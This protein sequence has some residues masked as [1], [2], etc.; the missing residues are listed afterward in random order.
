MNLPL[1]QQRRRRRAQRLRFK[2]KDV[3]ARVVANDTGG[4]ALPPK[5]AAW[6]ERAQ[7]RKGSTA[8][9]S[10]QSERRSIE[11]ENDDDDGKDGGEGTLADTAEME[12]ALAR[13]LNGQ[14]L[15]TA[16]G[17]QQC[18]EMLGGSLAPHEAQRILKL[19]D[20]NADA[21]ISYD[22]FLVGVQPEIT[23][24]EVVQHQQLKER[25]AFLFQDA[26]KKLAVEKQSLADLVESLGLEEKQLPPPV[27]K[28]PIW[29]KMCLPDKWRPQLWRGTG[30]REVKPGQEQFYYNK[31]GRGHNG[32]EPKGPTSQ[33]GGKG[34]GGEATGDQE[35]AWASDRASML[36]AE[37]S[38]QAHAE[39]RA[40]QE[41]ADEAAREAAAQRALEDE[42]AYLEVGDTLEDLARAMASRGIGGSGIG[43]SGIGGSGIGG[44]GN[45]GSGIGGSGNGG[46]GN[47][48]SG[49]AAPELAGISSGANNSSGSGGSSSR[50]GKRGSVFSVNQLESLAALG[51]SE[52]DAD[53]KAAQLFAQLQQEHNNGSSG[54]GVGGGGGASSS[55]L[56][57]AL[58]DDSMEAW[59]RKF[60]D[61]AIKNAQ[62]AEDPPPDGV[63]TASPPLLSSGPPKVTRDKSMRESI[64]FSHIGDGD[65]G[66]DGLGGGG[67]GDEAIMEALH[68]Q[69]L[70]EAGEDDDL[71]GEEESRSR[72][73]DRNSKDDSS[74]NSGG[75]KIHEEE[76]EENPFADDLSDN[77]DSAG[78]RATPSVGLEVRG[79]QRATSGRASILLGGLIDRETDD[80]G[81]E[82][83]EGGVGGGDGGY[84]PAAEQTPEKDL[85]AAAP[86]SYNNGA[87][88]PPTALSPGGSS[89]ADDN[90]ADDAG[91]P[92]PSGPGGDWTDEEDEEKGVEEFSGG[93]KFSDDS[94]GEFDAPP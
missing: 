77:E 13:D 46:S 45:G 11:G 67:G 10:S 78:Q 2:L 75:G 26:E 5:L 54:G 37:A 91:S 43:G 81:D 36:Q 19:V 71:E 49:A 31:Q 20:M 29:S 41:A 22:E 14:R 62:N 32:S 30:G 89:A 83:G 82:D 69:R 44:S 88:D 27:A 56:A 86:T 50:A 90:S 80:E 38:A 73:D 70:L 4:G 92:K 68:R 87:G 55:S 35:E 16:T 6:A 94:G 93:R 64:L 85:T 24:D 57:D 63:P 42:R 33:V 17:V 76:D 3:Y 40:A 48:G 8:L 34:L 9:L 28:E 51:V 74:G 79:L 61:E 1:D 53:A 52:E 47:G 60:Y 59:E 65:D 7:A 23:T 18:V 15:L 84:N 12:A 72:R 39:Q 58:G 25:M 21:L 66:D